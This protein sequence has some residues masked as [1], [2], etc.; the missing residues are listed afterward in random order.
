MKKLIIFLLMLTMLMGPVAATNN[1]VIITDPTGKDPNG[2][3][4]G[5]MS[6]AENMFQSTFLLSKDNHFAVLSGGEGDSIA[7]LGAIVETVKRLKSGASAADAASAASSYSG[8]RIM[9]GTATQGA[10]VAGSFDAYVVV[11]DDDGTITVTPYSGG[12]AS[13]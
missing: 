5:S 9:V 6:Y 10:A 11:V 4:A 2:A 1:V 7:R 8:I 3:A 13:L 12:L